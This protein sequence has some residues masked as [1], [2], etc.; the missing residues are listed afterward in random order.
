MSYPLRLYTREE[1]EV[2]FVRESSKGKLEPRLWVKD[3]RME[4]FS[5]FLPTHPQIFLCRFV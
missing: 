5:S 2:I 4:I 3:E 1:K